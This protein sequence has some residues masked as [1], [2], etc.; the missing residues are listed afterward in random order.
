MNTTN[1][2]KQNS[3]LDLTEPDVQAVLTLY[4]K[5]EETPYIAATRDLKDWLNKVE[6]GTETLVPKRNT[7]RLEN[8]LLPGHIILLWR[9]NFGTFTS[10]SVFPKYFE[11]DYGINAKQALTDLLEKNYARQFSAQESL[12]H[13]NAPQLKHLLKL[14]DVT[15][16]SK[17]KKAELMDKVRE[18]YSENDLSSQ[19]DVRGY[20]LTQDGVAL[21]AKHDEVVDKHPKKKF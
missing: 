6:I 9:I 21:L 20:A 4:D 14:K 13:L 2:N 15:G 12:T 19:F 1:I 11:Y 18:V 7:V 3:Q 8:D 5:H 10:E 16:Y 17:L